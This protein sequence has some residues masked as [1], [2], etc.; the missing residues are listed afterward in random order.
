MAKYD[1]FWLNEET[2]EIHTPKFRMVY[3][4]LL[5]AKGIKGDANSKPKFSVTALLPKTANLDLLKSEMAAALKTKFGADWAKKKGYKNCL[6]KTED[7]ER[8]AEFVEAFPCVLRASANEGFPPFIYGPNAQP[9]KGESSEI[10]SGR[11][12]VAAGKLFAFD[13]VSKGVSFS[14]NRIQ[15]LDHDEPIAGGRVA[16]A[17]GFEA[18]DA[19]TAPSG[20]KVEN[21]SD[22]F[23]DDE[24]P[25]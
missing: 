12:A 8:L 4:T 18:A 7:Q 21:A 24:L 22:V 14:L 16:T 17:S 6:L 1:T 20:K 25:F 3:P 2:G 13:N 10:Y 5:E 23:G 11:W 9:F 19:G 15:L